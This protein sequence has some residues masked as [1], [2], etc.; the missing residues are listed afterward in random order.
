M[1][2]FLRVTE[3]RTQTQFFH[4]CVPRSSKSVF[5]SVI[6]SKFMSLSEP[7]SSS[8]KWSWFPRGINKL[9]FVYETTVYGV[10]SGLSKYELPVV[11]PSLPSHSRYLLT[12]III[13]S[14]RT[15]MMRVSHDELL[16]GQGRNLESNHYFSQKLQRDIK[17][18]YDILMKKLYGFVSVIVYHFL[19][20]QMTVILK[21]LL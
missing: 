21:Q 5:H 4:M 6:L 8:I 10:Q 19:Y 7:V 16:S 2:G 3:L 12:K 18:E 15:S 14:T 17:F 9:V 13:D 1:M 20:V 11:S